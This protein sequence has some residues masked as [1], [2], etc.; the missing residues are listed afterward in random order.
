MQRK[1]KGLKETTQ[2]YRSWSNFKS[3]IT[4]HNIVFAS[5]FLIDLGIRYL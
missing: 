3:K 1:L 5:F 4:T 2:V